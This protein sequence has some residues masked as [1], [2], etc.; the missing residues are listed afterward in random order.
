MKPPPV[1]GW[2]R[3]SRRGSNC[4]GLLFAAGLGAGLRLGFAARAAVCTLFSGEAG[5]GEGGDGGGGDQHED[6][7]H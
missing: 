5:S 4:R 2:R 3:G 1:A 6:G 7:F